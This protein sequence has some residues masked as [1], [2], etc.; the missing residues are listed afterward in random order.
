MSYWVRENFFPDERENNG[1]RKLRRETAMEKIGEPITPSGIV[2]NGVPLE[3]VVEGQEEKE[4]INEIQQELTEDKA[5]K[6]K[7]R[8]RRYVRPKHINIRNGRTRKARRLTDDEIRREKGIAMKTTGSPYKDVM[9]LL[10]EGLTLTL[11]NVVIE[12]GLPDTDEGRKKA[13]NYLYL[14]RRYC[15]EHLDVARDGKGRGLYKISLKDEY[16]TG[17]T[18]QIWRNLCSVFSR[19]QKHEYD[20]KQREKKEAVEPV[21]EA[22][23][24]HKF[25]EGHVRQIYEEI[26]THVAKLRN[27]VANN[28][29]LITDLMKLIDKMPKG[30][31]VTQRLVVDV[32]F[33]FNFG[34]K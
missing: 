13:S 32:N 8:K 4:K 28:A 1:P 19:N 26:E 7:A 21:R 24:S 5:K 12:L 2:V 10:S 29:G 20:A 11:Y 9:W 22:M 15:P 34:K 3:E 16:R 18:D 23:A 31:P 27:S 17:P 6:K 25:V 14:I 30:D 33:N